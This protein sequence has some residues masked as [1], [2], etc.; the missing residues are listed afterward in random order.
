[1]KPI[2]PQTELALALSSRM[3]ANGLSIRD[4]ATKVEVSYEA[5]RRIIGGSQLPSKRLLKD[6]CD[7]LQMDFESTDQMRQVEDIRRRHGSLPA[8]MTGKNPELQPIEDMW[9]FLSEAEKE[10]IVALVRYYA[11]RN[12]TQPSGPSRIPKISPKSQRSQ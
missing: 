10:Q 6:L 12:V 3:L 8:K 7:I 4:L 5:I 11:H 1:L 9:A 2:K